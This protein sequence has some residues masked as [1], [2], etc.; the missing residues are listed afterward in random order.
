[1]SSHTTLGL[2]VSALLL[3]TTALVH[4]G[5]GDPPIEAVLADLEGSAG[6][7]FIVVQRCNEVTGFLKEFWWTLR[8]ILMPLCKKA[9]PSV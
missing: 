2:T 7:G 8:T 4:A 6:G 9:R 3:S 5:P 1:M